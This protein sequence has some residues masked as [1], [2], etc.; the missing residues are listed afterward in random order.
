MSVDFSQVKGIKIP[1]GNV[2]RITI[3]NTVV[4]QATRSWKEIQSASNYTIILNGGSGSGIFQNG[5]DYEDR[6]GGSPDWLPHLYKVNG[7]NTFIRFVLEKADS[8]TS[9]NFTT[10]SYYYINTTGNSTIPSTDSPDWE[11]FVLADTYG[12]D[13]TI[14]LD[15]RLCKNSLTQIPLFVIR[16]GTNEAGSNYFACSIVGEYD[17]DKDCY[18]VGLVGSR[19]GGGTNIDR[20]VIRYRGVSSYNLFGVPALDPGWITVDN[21]TRTMGSASTYKNI[22]NF[23]TLPAN[24]TKIKLTLK[25]VN[26][27]P[28]N[29][30][31]YNTNMRILQSNMG[32]AKLNELLTAPNTEFTL[33][34]NYDPNRPYLFVVGS[35]KN[36]WSASLDYYISLKQV[37]SMG[38][39]TLSLI[40]SGADEDIVSNVTP[41]SSYGIYPF[42]ITKIEAYFA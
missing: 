4:W 5:F 20:A 31:E 37:V 25:Y 33:E 12:E 23:A 39:I 29:S 24:P 9:N 28:N 36:V 21:T 34:V 18:Y 40:K 27:A 26:K 8:I 14:E 16:S 35:Y 42:S 6:I 15:L 30:T 2:E 1:Q 7:N 11:A 3:D 22:S 17:Q 41:S 32:F 19:Y 38:E 13:W 10:G